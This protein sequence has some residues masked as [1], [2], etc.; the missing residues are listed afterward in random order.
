[1]PDG[2]K[3][4]EKYSAFTGQSSSSSFCYLYWVLLT[5]SLSAPSAVAEGQSRGQRSGLATLL[6]ASSSKVGVRGD[7]FTFHWQG[8]CF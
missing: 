3:K 6:A 1:M 7:S 8:P 4:M 2:V 5:A